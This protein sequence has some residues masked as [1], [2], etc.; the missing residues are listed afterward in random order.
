MQLNF[1]V[2]EER[3]ENL[4]SISTFAKFSESKSKDIE[5]KEAEKQA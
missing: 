1:Q 4:Y 5:V 2:N 3:L